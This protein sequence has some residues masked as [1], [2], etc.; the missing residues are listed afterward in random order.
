MYVMCTAR[1]ILEEFNACCDQVYLKLYPTVFEVA[2]LVFFDNK[3]YVFYIYIYTACTIAID[4][5]TLCQYII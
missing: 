4:N 3:M 1:V 2:D 5:H